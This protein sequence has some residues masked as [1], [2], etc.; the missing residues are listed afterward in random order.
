MRQEGNAE[1][2]SGAEGKTAA[3]WMKNTGSV[4]GKKG[5][6]AEDVDC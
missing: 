1:S 3:T 6:S 5:V 2:T 4:G